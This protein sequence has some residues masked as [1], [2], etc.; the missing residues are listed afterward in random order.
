M[1][2]RPIHLESLQ[3]IKIIEKDIL[4]TILILFFLIVA[5]AATPPL[6][7][8]IIDHLLLNYWK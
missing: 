5:L 3:F 8:E 1:E 4:N 7:T 6:V 2:W